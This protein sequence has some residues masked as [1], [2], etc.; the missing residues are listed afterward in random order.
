MTWD[1]TL[2]SHIIDP[3]SVG[4]LRQSFADT[5]IGINIIVECGTSKEVVP[6]T[7]S[8]NGR[9]VT[10]YNRGSVP[11]SLSSLALDYPLGK[12]LTVGDSIRF[13]VRQSVWANAIPCDDTGTTPMP[14]AA[15][16]LIFENTNA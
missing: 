12:R 6:A 9:F 14:F 16:D 8:G 2:G 3:E 15:L 5:D 10:I 11:V 13:F 4:T 1:P 7:M